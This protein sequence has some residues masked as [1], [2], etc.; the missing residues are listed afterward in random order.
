MNCYVCRVETGNQSRPAL[1]V[2]QRCGAGICGAHLIELV[3]NPVAGLGGYTRSILICC[4]CSPSS[5]FLA[6]SSQSEN[7]MKE[8]SSQSRASGRNWWD[9]FWRRRPSELPKPEEAVAA[10]ERFLDHQRSQ[11]M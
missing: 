6:R 10:V 2:C 9:W 1:A 4:R 3:V 8:P 7:H 5:L 11:E